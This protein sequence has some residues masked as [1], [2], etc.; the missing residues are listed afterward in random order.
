M[1]KTLVRYLK[2]KYKKTT[3]RHKRYEKFRRM[4]HNTNKIH[5]G[6]SRKGGEDIRFTILKDEIKALL[7]QPIDMKT[8]KMDIRS[9]KLNGEAITS[10]YF[11][12][13]EKLK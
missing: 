4:K 11:N 10:T 7:P 5:R 8:F 2:R 3:K 13:F 12:N 6:R 1:V 9:D